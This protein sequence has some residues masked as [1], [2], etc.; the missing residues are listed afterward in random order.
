[1]DTP[2]TADQVD[3]ASRALD[4]LLPQ[5]HPS[6]SRVGL[7]CSYY[8][9]ELLELIQHPFFEEV[10][11]QVLATGKARLLQTAIIT[12]YP[13]PGAK[14]SYDQHI[15]M[16]YTLADLQA[17]PRRVV[18]SFFLWLTEVT[19]DRAPMMFR[20][21]SHLPLIEEWGRREEL[22]EVIPRVMGI[23]LADLPQLE[24]ADPEPILAR[25]GQVSVLTTAAVH[26][27]SVNI[28]DQPRKVVV[29]TFHHAGV[30]IGL[31]PAQQETKVKYDR[32]LRL[33][34][35]PERAHIVTVHHSRSTP[36]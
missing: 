35:R 10:A 21:G 20:P 9:E 11:K 22:Q 4:R 3:G 26:G 15:D 29:I 14:F 32:E 34:L 13:Q 31:P 28:G 8:D 1:M 30:E 24:F 19:D 36:C 33:R 27:A 7:T 17:T 25:A 5:Q 18:C 12:T 2:L 23:K 6:R 16:Q